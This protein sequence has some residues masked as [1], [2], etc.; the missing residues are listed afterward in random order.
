MSIK[1]NLGDWNGV[2]AVPSSVVDKY[3]KIAGATQLKVLLYVLRYSGNT[4]ITINK[5]SEEL[6]I[7]ADDIK[8]AIGFWISVGLIKNAEDELAPADPQLI[9][10]PDISL[11]EETKKAIAEENNTKPAPRIVTKT[12]RPDANFV[13]NRVANDPE[14][15]FMMQEAEMILSRPLSGGDS[16]SLIIMHDTDGLP[17]PVILMILQYVVSIGKGMKYAETVGASWSADGIN[18]IEQAEQK[19]KTLNNSKQAWKIIQEL[20]G[21]ESHSPSEKE[22]L[23]ATR[24]VCE[25]G[26]SRDVLRAAYEICIDAK[27]KYLPNYVNKVLTTWYTK[28]IK[29]IEQ[30]KTDSNHKDKNKSQGT[31]G[32]GGKPSF[33]L[34]EFENSSMFD[35]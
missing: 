14:I 16:S 20:F 33:D 24:W 3:I 1:I 27:G 23:N 28:G 12:Q 32:M 29:T 17:V 19:I 9:S 26:F 15:A 4:D 31:S 35:D 22:K 18:T 25:M 30:V 34:A 5:I 10:S 8:D 11:Y 21:L 6:N 7:S 13:S 2:F